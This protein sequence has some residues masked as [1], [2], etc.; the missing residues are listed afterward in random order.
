VATIGCILPFLQNLKIYLLANELTRQLIN[1]GGDL[2]MASE[3]TFSA[4]KKLHEFLT[5]HQSYPQFPDSNNPNQTFEPLTNGYYDLNN[6]LRFAVFDDAKN[7]KHIRIFSNKTNIALEYFPELNTFEFVKQIP[8]TEDILFEA[9]D[10]N[11]TLFNEEKYLADE[12]TIFRQ[13]SDELNNFFEEL[14]QVSGVLSKDFKILKYE[15]PSVNQESTTQDNLDPETYELFANSRLYHKA[16][17]LNKRMENIVGLENFKSEVNA[18]IDYALF[19]D[20]VKDNSNIKTPNLNMIISGNSGS[21]KS[22]ATDI[23]ADIY[24]ELNLIGNSSQALEV[25]HLNTDTLDDITGAKKLEETLENSKGKLIVVDPIDSFCNTDSKTGIHPLLAAIMDHIDNNPN[26]PPVVFNGSPAAVKT[27]LKLNPKLRKYFAS[28]VNCPDYTPDQLTTIFQ[29]KIY[30]MQIG[31][32]P[33]EESG[34]KTYDSAK[35]IFEEAVRYDS[36]GN[37]HFVDKYVQ[38]TIVEHSKRTSNIISPTD[39]FNVN[40]QDTANEIINEL[41]QM[42]D[43]N[44]LITRPVDFDDLVGMEDVKETIRDFVENIQTQREDGLPIND[45]CAHMVLTGSAGVGK[46]VTATLYANELFKAGYTKEMKLVTCKP[47]DLIAGYVGQTMLKTQEMI[48]KARGGVLFIDEAYALTGS[49]ADGTGFTGYG[50]DVLACLLQAMEDREVVV[51][52]AGYEKEMEHFL[53]VNEGMF[54]R[55]AY[56]MHVHIKDQTS[57][58]LLEIAKKNCAKKRQI[59]PDSCDDKIIEIMEAAK[60]IPKFGNARFAVNLA[61]AII[62]YNNK[63]LKTIGEFKKLNPDDPSETREIRPEGID[64]LIKSP[65]YSKLLK[66]LIEK[67]KKP[68]IKSHLPRGNEDTKPGAGHGPPMFAIGGPGSSRDGNI[69][70]NV[71]SAPAN[72]NPNPNPNV[73]NSS[74]PKPFSKPGA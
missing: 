6:T 13:D 49:N 40:V 47:S 39:L 16:V 32:G 18:L 62:K 44:Q 60:K 36:F 33:D 12:P 55:I 31:I 69:D 28:V 50:G 7:N 17:T 48:E 25:E 19:T 70:A 3:A 68:S 30:D 61:D 41:K 24:G 71:G 73:P 21:G 54:S 4:I 11:G 15:L 65:G 67:S 23:L 37:G 51:I 52:F 45:I 8:F 1:I 72:P 29:N 43:K 20:K 59:I 14:K 74:T 58:E 57:R 42:N 66:D 26:D 34:N 35:K 27:L 53:N 2:F 56:D 46:T 10:S 63:Y 64:Y 38:K 9:Y 5:T 22:F